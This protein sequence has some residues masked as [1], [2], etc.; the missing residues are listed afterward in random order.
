MYTNTGTSMLVTDIGHMQYT[1]YVQEYS[2]KEANIRGPHEL[3][4]FYEAVASA[5]P[6]PPT[7]STSDEDTEDGAIE[8][9]GASA[10]RSAVQPNEET[11]ADDTIA[12]TTEAGNGTQRQKRAAAR[13]A[14]QPK[15][16]KRPK[17]GQ[18][19]SDASGSTSAQ[20]WQSL[21][22]LSLGDCR[23]K[24]MSGYCRV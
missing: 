14:T 20:V 5:V 1:W 9:D 21:L 11:A 6:R 15:S 3:A 2:F 10:E 22:V 17:K 18:Q 24:L 12:A 8:A 16:K 7:N 4:E 23:C 19:A 13:A